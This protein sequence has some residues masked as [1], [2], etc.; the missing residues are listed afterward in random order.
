M[1][2]LGWA[3]SRNTGH[4]HEITNYPVGETEIEL[5]ADGNVRITIPTSEIALSGQ[6]YFS[7]RLTPEEVEQIHL[8][9]K[10]GEL[11]KRIQKLE[12]LVGEPD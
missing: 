9:L 12:E 7:L 10:T 2:I 3:H 6:Y 4:T 5:D 8:E 1:K 11:K